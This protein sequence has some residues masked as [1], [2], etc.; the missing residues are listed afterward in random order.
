MWTFLIADVSSPIHLT[1]FLHYFELVPDPKYKCLRDTKTKLRSAG[2][3][4]H[5]NFHFFQIAISTDTYY[6]KLLKEFPSITKLP[7][8]NQ[9]VKHNTIHYIITK[10]HPVV[11]RPQRLAP[12]RLKIAKTEFQN[13]MHVGRLQPS[14]SNYARVAT[15]HGS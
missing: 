7:N 1:D 12:D 5:A 13:M 11:V 14:K 2:H 9:P 8:P 15:S 4:K 3:L 6:H 10:N